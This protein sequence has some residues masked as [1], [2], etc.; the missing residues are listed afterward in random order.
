MRKLNIFRNLL[1]ISLTCIFPN[2]AF[3]N[4]VL[5]EEV[6][7]D[8]KIAK[9]NPEKLISFYDLGDDFSK[10]TKP[11]FPLDGTPEQ[12]SEKLCAKP[13]LI[14]G[15]IDCR[16]MSI[17]GIIYKIDDQG[18]IYEINMVADKKG[19]FPKK[20][21]LEIIPYQSQETLIKNF[22]KNGLVWERSTTYGRNF[23]VSACFYN[24]VQTK[25]TCFEYNKK[26]QIYKVAIFF[27]SSND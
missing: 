6:I 24:D 20:L 16:Y 17:D 14:D 2:F 13:A 23:H 8:S 4:L 7:P 1:A 19:K 10:L 3:A 22:E 25:M 26:M 15:R 9:T 18:K 11:V 27:R 12:P 21:P 5:P